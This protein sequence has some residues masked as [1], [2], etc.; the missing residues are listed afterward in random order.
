MH[1]TADKL[2]KR[3]DLAICSYD[4]SLSRSKLKEQI[5]NLTLNSK[6]IDKFSSTVRE[7]DVTD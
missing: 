5:R 3:I 4:K 2:F 6:A 1:F 7:G